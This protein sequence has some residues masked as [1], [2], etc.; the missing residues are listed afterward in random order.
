MYDK[1]ALQGKTLAEL[2]EIGRQFGIKAQMRKQELADKIIE[3]SAQQNVAAVSTESEQSAVE[4]PQRRPGRPRKQNVVAEE[5][6]AVKIGRVIQGEAYRKQRGRRAKDNKE[7]GEHLVENASGATVAQTTVTTNAEPT[8]IRQSIA[9]M[10][11]DAA[12]SVKRHKR[13]RITFN[14][15]VRNTVSEPDPE[16][17]LLQEADVDYSDIPELPIAETPAAEM[18]K[19][20]E[21]AMADHEDVAAKPLPQPHIR[22]DAKDDFLGDVEGEGVLEVMP[23]GYGFLRSTD[24]NYLNSP[25]DIYVSPSQIKLFGLK[26]GDTVQ[27]LIRPPKE[28][29]KYFPLVKVNRINGL[30]PDEVRDRVQ[31]EYMTP[32]FPS[33]KFNLTG[34]GHNNLSTRVIDLFAPIGKGQRGLIVAQPKTGKTMLLQSIANAIADNHPEVYLI[35]LLIDERP[36]EVTE[37]ARHVKAEVVASTFDEQAARHV[38]VAEMVHEKAKR[39]VECG[40]DVVILLDSIT[41]LARAYNTVQPASGKVLSGGVDANALHKPKRFFGAAR[42]TEERGSLTIIATALIDTGS[43]MDEV[44]FEEFKGT[45]NMELQLDRQLANKR[46]YPAVNIVASGTRREDLLLSKEVMQ[47]IWVLRRYLADMNPTEAMEVIKKHMES[48][49]SNEELLVT[50]NQ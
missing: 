8:G 27:G 47:K 11:G 16:A 4:Q 23:D 22:R 14:K 24:Y 35:V 31:F 1:D 20:V 30:S 49:R 40:H 28:G 6:S 32:L 41:R 33:E 25:D 44:I 42:N 19:Q 17:E 45:G 3:L 13:E 7:N 29:E 12:N 48:T 38:K 34:N 43:K 18:P 10:R 9:A 26:V 50:M 36:E 39:M 37:M 2:R 46:I 15:A 21:L 5:K